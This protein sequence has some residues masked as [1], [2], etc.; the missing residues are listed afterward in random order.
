MKEGS[1]PRV[2]LVPENAPFDEEQRAWLNGFLAGVLGLAASEPRSA[3]APAASGAAARARAEEVPAPAAADQLGASNAPARDPAAKTGQ[4]RRLLSALAQL[5]CGQ[6]GYSCQGYAQALATGSEQDTT[7]CVPGGTAT[8]ETLDALLAG[9]ARVARGSRAPVELDVALRE[10]RRKASLPLAEPS[11]AA[12]PGSPA[13]GGSAEERRRAQRLRV[14][15]QRRLTLADAG[16]EIREVVLD[17]NGSQLSYRPGDSLAIFPHND[18]DLVRALLRALGARGQE[19]VTTPQGSCEAWRCLLENVDITHVREETLRLFA[20]TL[21]DGDAARA[22]A[23]LRERGLPHGFDLLDLINMFPAIRPGVEQVVSTLGA[24]EPRLYSIASSP[25]S[26]PSELHLAVRMVRRE[27]AGRERKGVA[28]NFLT[29]GVFKGDDL[30]ASVQSTE[31]YVA[32][33]GSVPLILLGAGTG[34]ARHRAFLAE[35]EARGRKGNTWLILA[36][37]FEG[38][39]MLYQS[40]LEAWSKVGVLE[41]LDVIKLGQRGRRSGP[42]DILRRRARR[43]VSWLDR[44]AAVYACGESK[45]F[46]GALNDTLVEVLG[47]QGNMTPTEA[48]DFLHEMRRD[49]RYVEEVY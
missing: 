39:E 38:D 28:S 10:P 41:H 40:D 1:D 47:R 14:K 45:A 4:E 2:P 11:A 6:C 15:S 5:D 8:R 43:V 3:A 29:E 19:L 22:L 25:S 36:S 13:G 34:V 12:N 49:G 21:P 23:E 46:S 37:C 16:S 33:E 24:L 20:S 7:L 27:R 31:R 26:H 18:P 17:L 35:L 44:G 42:H 32:V 9:P 48:L 30:A